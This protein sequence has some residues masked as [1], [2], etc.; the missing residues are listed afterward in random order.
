M[1]LSR[2]AALQALLKYEEAGAHLRETLEEL[3]RESP[4]LSPR[5][6]AFCREL[7]GGVVRRLNTRWTGR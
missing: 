4:G 5:D 6:R 3:F 1:S 7:A 2:E